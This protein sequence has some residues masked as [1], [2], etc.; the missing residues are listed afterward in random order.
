M[1][2][3]VKDQGQCGSCWAFSAIGAIESRYAISSGTLLSLSEQ[4]LV[5]CDTE[6]PAPGPNQ[7]CNGGFMNL[8]IQYS[9]DKGNMLESDYPYTAMDGTCAFDPAQVKVQNKGN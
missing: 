9:A 6:D 4:Q 2:N 3:A 5:D 8:A 1:V 7:G